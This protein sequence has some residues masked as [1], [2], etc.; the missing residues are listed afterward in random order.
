MEFSVFGRRKLSYGVQLFLVTLMG[1]CFWWWSYQAQPWPIQN[2]DAEDMAQIARNWQHFELTSSFMPLNGL[3]FLRR[4]GISTTPPWPAITRFPLTPALTALAFAL[5]GP[6]NLGA[7]LVSGVLTALTFPLIFH[8]ARQLAQADIA[9]WIAVTFLALSGDLFWVKNLGMTEPAGWT[10]LLA[11]ACMMLHAEDLH[12]QSSWQAVC[13]GGILALQILN[14]YTAIVLAPVLLIYV[15]LTSKQRLRDLVLFC[16]ALSLPLIP[17][18]MYLLH[19]TG[20]PF[21]NVQSTN[22]LAYQ[23]PDGQSA[24]GWYLMDYI[25][26]RDFVLGHRVALWQR[27]IQSVRRLYQDIPWLMPPVGFAFFIAGLLR[28][29]RPVVRWVQGMAAVLFAAT[30]ASVS[31]LAYY[32]PRYYVVFVPLALAFA[33][34]AVWWILEHNGPPVKRTIVYTTCAIC[35]VLLL[36]RGASFYRAYLHRETP[37]YNPLLYIDTAPDNQQ[38]IKTYVSDSSLVASNV[39]WSVAWQAGRYTIPIPPQPEDIP[40]LEVRYALRIHAIY[41]SSHFG[42]DNSPP[43]WKIWNTL[44][45]EKL[46]IPG[47]TLAHQFADGSVL[48]LR[49]TGTP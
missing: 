29:H 30:A 7:A 1:G 39:P 22:A 31:L 46:P 11:M 17:W 43:E 41:L 37:Q 49:E 19:I 36:I 28:A 10:L 18:N 25:E 34:D 47:F 24:L 23:I 26:V 15:G 27:A 2:P 8:V 32:I 33:A 21:Y 9:G 45:Q 48:Y 3:E 5:V 16:V 42:I 40:T 6:T 12:V 38:A 44:R 14:R 13:L 4:Q 20:E 35:S